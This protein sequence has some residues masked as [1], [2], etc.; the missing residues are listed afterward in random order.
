MK[1]SYQIHSDQGYVTVAFEGTVTLPELGAHVQTVWSDKRWR[2]TYNGIIDC[3]AATLNITPAEIRNLTQ[4]M[5][6]DPRCSFAKWAF[7]V[8][9]AET[10]AMLRNVNEVADLKSAL[11]IFFDR[12]AAEAWLQAPRHQGDRGADRA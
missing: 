8:S 7:V 1:A 10:F 11:R 3:A 5:M 6:S 2:N 12:R 4:A 9:N